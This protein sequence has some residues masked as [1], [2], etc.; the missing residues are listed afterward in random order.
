MKKLLVGF[1]LLFILFNQSLSQQSIS[2]EGEVSGVWNADTI[3]VIGSITI[4][5]RQKLSISPGCVVQFTG[6]YSLTIE[7]SLVAKGSIDDSIKFTVADTLGFHDFSLPQGGWNRILIIDQPADGDSIVFEF[8][9]FEFSKTNM[10]Q[11]HGGAFYIEN[12]TKIKIA[13][14]VFDNNRAFVNGGAIFLKLSRAEV[15]HNSFKNS[16]AGNEELWG[17]GGAICGVSSDGY[18]YRNFFSNNISTGI[19][20]A[21]S[22]EFSIPTLDANF[23]Q[24]NYS[25]LGGALSFLRATG[26]GLVSNNLFSYN[27]STFFGGAI[28][29]VSASPTLTNN[30]I[31]N[32]F[33]IYGGGL[34]C[35][36]TSNPKVYNS[37]LWGNTADA[38]Y[39]MQ[40]FIWDALSAPEFYNCNFEHGPQDFKP[41]GF[42]GVYEDCIE[43]YPFFSYTEGCE[44]EL[45]DNSPNIDAGAN[46]ISGFNLPQLDLIGNPRVSN[47]IVDIG[48]F[49]FQFPLNISLINETQSFSVTFNYCRN[50][51][52]LLVSAVFSHETFVSLEVFNIQ[53]RLLSFQNLGWVESGMY[54]KSISGVKGLNPGIYIGKL[55]DGKNKA[56]SK[57]FVF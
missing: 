35:N 39:G 29:L 26:G 6:F 47:S 53:G 9:K 28:A 32:N 48:A 19:G 33:S 44:F 15:V 46:L 8:C 45:L 49:E 14:C 20:G 52:Q 12:S 4:P 7:G 13:N 37:V 57:F 16:F 21:C 2:V 22:F 25:A 31:V 3:Y 34:Y 51:Q 50:S 54:Y 24:D 18:L 1:S 11:L 5:E 17:Y 56:V 27:G 23:F 40:V 36:E 10:E 55:S 43:L 41:G 30:T 38:G 42:S